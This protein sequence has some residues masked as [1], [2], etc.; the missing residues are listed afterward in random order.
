MLNQNCVSQKH[1]QLPNRPKKP[2]DRAITS[3]NKPATACWVFHI[4]KSNK[5]YWFE[6]LSLLPISSYGL[7]PMTLDTWSKV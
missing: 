7:G 4:C 2:M 5:Y 3:I 1:L 6:S